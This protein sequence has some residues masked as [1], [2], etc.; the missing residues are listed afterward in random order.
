MD[1]WTPRPL[2]YDDSHTQKSGVSSGLAL[3]LAGWSAIAERALPRGLAATGEITLQGG[4]RPID[5]LREKL[6]AARLAE[7]PLVLYPAC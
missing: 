7:C 1:G 5:G 4:V 3:T 6:A 2:R